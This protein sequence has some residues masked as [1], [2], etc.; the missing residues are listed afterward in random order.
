MNEIAIIGGNEKFIYFIKKV[1]AVMKVNCRVITE[2][3]IESSKYYS[4]VVLQSKSYHYNLKLNTGYYFINMDNSLIEGSDIYGNIV[5][6]GF[7]NKNTV[8]ISSIDSE[9][10]SF[11]YCL[12]RYLNHNAFAM[13]QPEEIPVVIDFKNDDELYAAMVGITVAFLENGSI[14]ETKL[15]L[16]NKK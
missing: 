4:Y 13:L 14:A 7:G 8:T 1:L 6:Y 15:E 16:I 2:V 12:Q 11:V 3:D 10:Q 9:N 5:T